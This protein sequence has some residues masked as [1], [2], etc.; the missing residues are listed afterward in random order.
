CPGGPESMKDPAFIA[1]RKAGPVALMTFWPSGDVSMA[2][3]LVQWFVF[4][5]VVGLFSGYLTSRALPAGA[6]YLEGF[7]FA[8]TLTLS[9][10][11]CGQASPSAGS[12]RPDLHY[13]LFYDVVDDYVNRRTPFRPAHVAF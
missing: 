5:L 10:T 1:K 6:P 13:L 8:G 9:L 3:M 11:G 7:R 4:C 2:P 12:G